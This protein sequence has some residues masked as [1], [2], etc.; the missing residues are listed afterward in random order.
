MSCFVIPFNSKTSETGR[1]YKDKRLN[2]LKK[3]R[4]L[5]HCYS[6]SQFDA[7]IASLQ[8]PTSD[9]DR[10]TAGQECPHDGRL[11]D[12]LQHLGRRRDE[13]LYLTRV[14]IGIRGV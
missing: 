3:I 8:E 12:A 13:E 14:L 10:I 11:P 5:N 2:I 9:G 6:C 1:G 4:V 7:I